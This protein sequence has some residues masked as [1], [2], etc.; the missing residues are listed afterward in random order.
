MIA[1][2]NT[3]Y[4]DNKSYYDLLSK[5][6]EKNIEGRCCHF[7]V[8]L[9]SLLHK[10]LEINTYVEIGVHNGTSMSCV[11]QGPVKYAIGIDLFEETISRYTPDKLSLKRTE[12]NIHIN[13]KYNT[14]IHLI[15][16]NS[17]HQETE[18]QLIK[19]LDTKEIDVLF[20]D[21]LHEL[22]GIKNDFEK[23]TKYVKINGLVIF[24]DYEPRYPDILLY[25]DKYIKTNTSFKII[26]VFLENELIIQ[27]L[28]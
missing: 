10:F 6:I 25:V 27:K 9:L 26:G 14:N 4:I 1:D 23:Y 20:I 13:N 8:I 24:D 21:G 18:N 12:K 11:L 28:S 16:G 22:N 15:K 3:E 19:I 5:Q 2:I 17:F 7:K